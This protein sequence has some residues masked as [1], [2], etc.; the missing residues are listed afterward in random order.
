MGFDKFRL[1]ATLGEDEFKLV[2]DLDVSL[3]VV[4]LLVFK[5]VLDLAVNLGVVSLLLGFIRGVFIDDLVP[6][7]SKVLCLLPPFFMD[8]LFGESCSKPN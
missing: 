7:E 4:S 1:L 3:G 2:L 5:L 6:G 8:C